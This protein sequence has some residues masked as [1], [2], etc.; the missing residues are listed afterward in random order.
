M[1]HSK[2]SEQNPV[3]REICSH[4][5]INGTEGTWFSSNCSED[6]TVICM[7]KYQTVFM[8]PLQPET[9]TYVNL[10]TGV[11]LNHTTTESLIGTSKYQHLIINLI[12]NPA[13]SLK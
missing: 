7:D 13:K 3:F 1:L 12:F 4:V 6:H 2:W 8:L 5:K 10:S 9:T 11:L